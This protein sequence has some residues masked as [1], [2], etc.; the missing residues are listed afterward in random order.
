VNRQFGEQAYNWWLNTTVWAVI[1]APYVNG[2]ESNTLPD[3]TAGTG[4]V[5]AARHNMAQLWCDEGDCS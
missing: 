4:L 1:E 5:G 3:G 2:I